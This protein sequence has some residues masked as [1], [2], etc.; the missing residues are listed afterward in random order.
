MAIT[1]E[2]L[3][4]QTT[5][6]NDLALVREKILAAAKE[7]SD[8][9][10]HDK[11]E[12][13][14]PAVRHV[15]HEPLVLSAE[16]NP[17]LRALDI[18]I[19][20]A[21]AGQAEI[22]SLVRLNSREFVQAEGKQYFTYQFEK[23]KDGKYPRFRELFF[24]F[25][26]MPETK[27]P[28][29]RNLDPLTDEEREGKNM[30]EGFWAPIDIAEKIASDEIGGTELVMY[31]EWVYAILHVKKIDLTKTREENGVTYALVLLKDG[32]MEYFCRNCSKILNIGN[33]EMFF[34]N[35]PAYLK[36]HTYAYDAETG[37]LYLDPI[38]KKYMAYHAVEYPTLENLLVIEG[39]DNFTLDG[40]GFTG[41]TAAHPCDHPMY[42]YQANGVLGLYEE[43]KSGRFETAAVLAKSVRGLTVKNCRFRE[44]GGYGVKV[45]DDSYRTTVK[46]ST[47]EWI[48]MSAVAIGNAVNEWSNPKNRTFAAHVENNIFQKIGYEYPACPCIYIGQVDGLKILHNTI[49]NC[50]YSGMS[51]G[52]NWD[53]VSYELGE[54]V[55]IRDAEI[56]YN[57]IYNYM[58]RLRDGGAIY[59]LGS[60]CN[61]LSCDYRF[62]RMH[63][64]F[65]AISEAGEFGGKY[66]YYCDGSAS[67]WEVRDSVIIGCNIPIFSQPHPLALSY[68][69][70]FVNIYSTTPTHPSAHVPGRD[71]ITE[72]Y[73]MVE[74]GLDALLEQH[75]EAKAIRDAAGSSLL[76]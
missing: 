26:R 7:A 19:R 12:V 36:E 13:V 42:T 29:W 62:N 1:L 31:I 58:D 37:K 60:N 71:V 73:V 27:S 68:H 52:W 56:A 38:N 59:V 40:V 25:R 23:E 17:E 43:G 6:E 41:A 50:A 2:S 64:N 8:A 20:G 28:V 33:R 70:R 3:K 4:R 35:S 49:E 48:S 16:K 72:N 57:Y 11:I 18:T 32:E 39:L 24:N 69:N 54:S 76:L 5:E 63:D 34:Q 65:A 9:G 46:D 75:P 14:L 51:V 45:A 55:N 67:N 53:P 66:G 30:R 22:S 15:L 61:R 74:E 47:F 44:L 10:R 21:Y